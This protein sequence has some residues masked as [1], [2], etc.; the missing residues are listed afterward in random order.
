MKWAELRSLVAGTTAVVGSSGG[1]CINPLIRNLD[2]GAGA[3]GIPGYTLYYSASTVTDRFEEGDI[4]TPGS[5]FDAVENHVA[6]GVNGSGTHEISHMMSI[7]MEGPGQIYVHATD[8]TTAQLARMADQGTAIAWSPRSNLDLYAATTPAD[9]AHTL[10]VPLTLAPDWTWSGSMSPARELTCAVEYLQ[11]RDSDISDVTLWSWTTSEAARILNLDGELGGLSAGMRA[12]ISVFSYSETPYRVVVEADPKDTRLVLRDGEALYG[13]P[14]MVEQLAANPE[15]CEDISACGES[16]SIC[17]KAGTSGDDAQTAADIE[18]I[19]SAAL[20]AVSMP[21]DLDYAND[22]LGLFMCEE[23]RAS[24]D[25]SE[26][27]EGDEDGDGVADDE[28]LCAWAYDP[29]QRD[30]DGDGVGDACDPCPLAADATECSHTPG[31]IDGDGELTADDNC[32][33]LANAD[34]A[35][36]DGD[37]KGDGCDPCP[38]EYNPGDVGCTFSLSDIRDPSSALHPGEGSDVRVEGVIVTGIR[39]G[40]GLYVQE[41]DAD[42]YGGIFIYDGGTYSSGAVNVGDVITVSGV[43]SEYY[44]LS[45]IGGPEITVTGTGESVEP[46]VVETTCDVGTDGPLAEPLEGMVVSVSDVAVT[47]S[48]PDAP[49]DY[50]EFELDECLRVDDQLSE[51]LVPQ[52]PEG[53]TYSTLTGVLTYTYGHAKLEP[54]GLEDVVD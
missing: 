43:Y 14:A 54:R 13:T 32:P 29:L 25:I 26:P 19:L 16:R 46:I 53:T 3:S 22:L 40:S 20:G 36:M 39:S 10:G 52:P 15:W 1:A 44:G 37:G 12:D 5:T 45:Q 51:V 27:S 17:A 8:A 30:H 42:M 21:A 31:D 23:S 6:E 33:W 7:G 11:T 49:S 28:D 2:E 18:E 35:D 24:C 50:G 41:P 47:N 9:V 34:Q 48:N 4:I 38:E